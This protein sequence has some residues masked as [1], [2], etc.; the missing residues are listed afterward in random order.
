MICSKST[1]IILPITSSIKTFHHCL[2][3]CVASIVPGIIYIILMNLINGLMYNIPS[4]IV[5]P[6]PNKERNKDN[7]DNEVFISYL[8]HSLIQCM[9]HTHNYHH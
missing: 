6:M 2:T 8:A 5:N 1:Y 3:V 9:K 7:N 4:V